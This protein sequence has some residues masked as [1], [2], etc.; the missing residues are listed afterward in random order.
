MIRYSA[1]A[2]IFLAAGS[3]HAGEKT[4]DKTFSV[5]AGGTLTVDADSAS[6]EVAGGDTNQVTVHM[7]YRASDEEL[8]RMVLDAAQKDDGVLVTMRRQEK[9]SWFS[10][11][12]TATATS[13]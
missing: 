8:A 12:G 2:L 1:I 5:A 3:A 6:V 7:R 13:R 10:S 11:C 4:L 9:K